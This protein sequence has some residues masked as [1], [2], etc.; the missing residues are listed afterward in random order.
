MYQFIASLQVTSPIDKDDRISPMVTRE[1]YQKY[2]KPSKEKTS[3]SYSG[4]HFGH[5]KAASE[6]DY[7]LEV[8]AL[9]PKLW[10]PP[11]TLPRD[12]SKAYQ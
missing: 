10:C 3:S 2:W 12:G 11:D 5:W 8:H 7:L 9:L 1:D 4:L 6:S